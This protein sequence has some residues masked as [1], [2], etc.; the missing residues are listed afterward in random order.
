MQVVNDPMAFRAFCDQARHETASASSTYGANALAAVGLVLTMGAL[1][2]G[3]LS[4]VAEARR[5]ARVVALTVFVNPTQFAPGE[6]LAKY[7]RTLEADL[8][9]CQEAGVDLVFVP[10]DNA[11]YPTGDET[12]ISVLT[13]DKGLCGVSRP[14]HF[15]GVC[16]VVAKFLNLAGPCVA[17]FGK[18]DYQQFR[19]IERMVTDL[20]LPV[21]VIGAETHREADGLAM[22]SRNRYLSPEERS[23]ALAIVGAL[24]QAQN[25]F[26]AGLR[27]RSQLLEQTQARLSAVQAVV[28]YV[29]IVDAQTLAPLPQA[30]PE[31]NLVLAIAV[32]LGNTR[33]IDNC[34]LDTLV[35]LGVAS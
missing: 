11:M 35:T 16:T 12:R 29:D 22:S 7:P 24:R 1:H 30:L 8:A 3:H 27:S 15:T 26:H 34:R 14:Q 4:L 33:L 2:A 17:V 9:L 10:R 19:V 18:K 5:R 6:D 20:F 21:S 31:T 23:R 13:L 25:A 28:D 32:K